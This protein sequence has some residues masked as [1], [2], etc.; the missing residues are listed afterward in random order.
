M[1]DANMAG[2][3][4]SPDKS[5]AVTFH[6]L[7]PK[8]TWKWESNTIMT[9]RFGHFRLG[10]WSRDV[11]VFEEYRDLGELGLVEMRCTLNFD[12]D[13]LKF[14]SPAAYKYLIYA[15]QSGQRPTSQAY[16]YLHNAP[17]HGN[18]IINRCLVIPRDY[19]KAKGIT[20]MVCVH[21]H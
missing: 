13:L 11:G 2:F 17:S 5:I 7:V 4:A 19:C 3:N 14:E 15:P 18:G 12:V 21:E 6:A 1:A 10:K 8:E 9:M 16:E 20:I